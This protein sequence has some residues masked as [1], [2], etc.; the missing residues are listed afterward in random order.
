MEY[1]MVTYIRQPVSYG[2]V[3]CA[4]IEHCKLDGEGPLC[5]ME[6]SRMEWIR[7]T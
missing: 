6:I 4:L 7:E 3:R 2:I 5:Q 1:M